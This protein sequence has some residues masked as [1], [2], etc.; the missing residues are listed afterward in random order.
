LRILYEVYSFRLMPSAGKWITG[1]REPFAYLV[2]S[3][4]TFP[5][6]EQIVSIP[7]QIGFSNASFQRLSGGI[8][9][10]CLAVKA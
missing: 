1:V 7:E 8:A 3:I 6:P 4:R 10:V 9:V 5:P 2:E